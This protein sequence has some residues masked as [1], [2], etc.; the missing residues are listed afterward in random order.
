M[1]AAIPFRKW[2]VGALGFALGQWLP[3][4]FPPRLNQLAFGYAR[5]ACIVGIL[6]TVWFILGWIWR[7][8]EPNAKTEERME[9]GLAAAIGGVL[10]VMAVHAQMADTHIGNTKWVYTRDGYEAVGEDV[11][12]LGPDPDIFVMLIM[13]AVTAFVFS[14]PKDHYLRRGSDQ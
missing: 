12:M 7:V 1:K 4:S 2:F 10:L 3:W 11:V 6:L 13:G 9:R 5:I 14:L 8:W